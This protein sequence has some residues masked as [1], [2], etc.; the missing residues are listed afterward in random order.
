MPVVWIS[1][2][3]NIIYSLYEIRCQCLFLYKAQKRELA[4][5]L[6][7]AQPAPSFNHFIEPIFS[8]SGSGWRMTFSGESLEYQ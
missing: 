5:R 7:E 4:I 6:S 8:L 2:G 1:F 3:E